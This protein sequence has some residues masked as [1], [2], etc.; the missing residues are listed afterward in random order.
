MEFEFSKNDGG[1]RVIV[2]ISPTVTIITILAV[3][4]LFC[5][6]LFISLHYSSVYVLTITEDACLIKVKIDY[7]AWK[8]SEL[9]YI[10]ATHLAIAGMK[11]LDI[12]EDESR[13]KTA[14]LNHGVPGIIFN[15][16]VEYDP[17]VARLAKEIL[18]GRKQIEE[19]DRQIEKERNELED[20]KKKEKKL[21]M[22]LNLSA[23]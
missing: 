19:L 18:E 12:Y 22:I 5:A 1:E 14:I 16:K 9:E 11:V 17:R 21:D 2:D 4:A 23:H 8:F 6:G 7:W 3:I 10:Q 20:L 15:V 13:I